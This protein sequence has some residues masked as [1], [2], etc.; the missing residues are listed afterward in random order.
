VGP[1]ESSHSFLMSALHMAL[2]VWLYTTLSSHFPIGAKELLLGWLSFEE[3]GSAIDA[4]SVSPR[5]RSWTESPPQ[6]I[7]HSR[8]HLP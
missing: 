7:R 6:P 3:S 8:H 4:S 1:R 5:A 2:S